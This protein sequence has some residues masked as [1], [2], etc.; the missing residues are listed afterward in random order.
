MGKLGYWSCGW[1]ELGKKTTILYRLLVGEVVTTI[2]TICF[3]METVTYKD[4]TFQ[5]WDLGGQTS[6]RPYW[7]CYYSKTDA[8]IYVVDSSDQDGMG[9]SK[10]ELV[11]MLEISQSAPHTITVT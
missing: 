4:L 1:M 3:N 7:H 11:A 2:T 9:I 5:V 6:I 10:S 8:V